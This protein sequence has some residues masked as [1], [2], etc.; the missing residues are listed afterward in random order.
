MKLSKKQKTFSELLASF[1]KSTLNFEQ[2]ETKDAPHILCIS[3]ITY[4]KNV[5]R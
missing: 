5:V 2:F 1:L 3:D 4:C